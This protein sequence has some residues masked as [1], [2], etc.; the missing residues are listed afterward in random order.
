MQV[1]PVLYKGSESLKLIR[2][3]G[4]ETCTSVCVEFTAAASPEGLAVCCLFLSI[5]QNRKQQIYNFHFP[6]NLYHLIVWK[7]KHRSNLSNSILPTL[8]ELR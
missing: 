8:Q 5:T 2:Q 1:A 4:S 7:E 3:K 6:F